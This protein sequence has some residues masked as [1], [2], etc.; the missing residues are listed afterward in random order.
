LVDR[1]PLH[2]LVDRGMP[3][4]ANAHIVLVRLEEMLAAAATVRDPDAVEELHELRKAAKHLRYA[5]EIF[6]SALGPS[7]RPVLKRIELIQEHLGA[8]HDCDVRLPLLHDCLAREIEREQRRLVRHGLPASL[9]AE[10]IAPLIARTRLERA[11]R[12][13]AFLADWDDPGPLALAES[14]RALLAQS[15]T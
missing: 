10:G 8:I 3:M 2:P 13:A 14:V 9:A 11:E 12:Y 6:A 4:R 15:E 5:I 1:L 7:V